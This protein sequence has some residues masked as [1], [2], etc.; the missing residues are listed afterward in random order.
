MIQNQ[1][2]EQSEEYNKRLSELKLTYEQLLYKHQL[3]F[4]QDKNS[5]YSQIKISIP[6]NCA[7]CMEN[8]KLGSKVVGLDCNPFKHVF[9]WKCL[10]SW[11]KQQR[12]CPLCRKQIR[13]L[14]PRSIF[15]AQ[16]LRQIDR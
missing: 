11:L 12:S 16:D 6:N 13:Y 1:L 14:L 2:R 15:Y 10:L 8:F 4:D 7:V 3:K 9:H 5:E